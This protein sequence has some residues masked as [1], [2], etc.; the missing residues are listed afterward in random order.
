MDDDS[1]VLMRAGA[2]A[3]RKGVEK[4]RICRKCYLLKAKFVGEDKVDDV[5]NMLWL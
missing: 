5:C 2:G 1:G 4:S 3:E